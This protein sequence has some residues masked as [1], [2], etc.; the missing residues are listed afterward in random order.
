MGWRNNNA[1]TVLT[2]EKIAAIIIVT[3]L[4][5]FMLIGNTVSIVTIVKTP[6]LRNQTYYWFVLNLAIV[7]LV[8]S[9]TVVPIHTVWEAHGPWPFGQVFCN[10]V[11]F[12]DMAFSAL[13]SYS[14]VLVSLDKFV[15]ITKP[16]LYHHNNASMA[17]I[18]S[19]IAVWVVWLT[20]SAISV[21]AGIARD[22]FLDRNLTY[23]MDPCNFVMTDSYAISSAIVSFFIPLIIIVFTS[24]KIVCV[25]KRHICRIAANKL[26]PILDD[27]SS[28]NDRTPQKGTEGSQLSIIFTRKLQQT[29]NASQTCDISQSVTTE[30]TSSKRLSKGFHPHRRTFPLCRAFGTV[31]IVT[32]FFILMFAPYWFAAIIDVGCNCIPTYIFEDYLMVFYYMHS[33]VNPYIYMATD[34]RYKKAI[35]SCPGSLPQLLKVY[36]VLDD[37]FGHL[38]CFSTGAHGRR[39]QP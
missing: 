9:M 34:R 20:F 38:F 7:D 3:I 13:A 14:T 10:F 21:F 5:I 23:R 33:L 1:A 2:T 29:T 19:V 22:P 36:A 35:G 12:L 4:N 26:S 11:I 32:V 28:G 25:V 8:N 37:M 39:Y 16:F 30:S 15:C 27:I 18:I 31:M 24:I 17:A 6:S